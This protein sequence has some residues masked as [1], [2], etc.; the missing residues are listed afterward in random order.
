MNRVVVTGIGIVSPLGN[1]AEDFWKN[2]VSG[3]NGVSKINSFDTSEYDVHIAGQCKIDLQHYLDKK[4]LNKN[5]KFTAY[6]IIAADQAFKDSNLDLKKINQD[7]SGVIIGSGIG[8][9]NTFESQYKKLLKN[10]KRVSPFFIPGMIPDIASGQVAIKYGFTGVNYSILSACASSSHCIG[11]AYRNI[12][13]GYA[14]IIITGGSESTITPSAIAGFSNMKALTKN[15]D[16]KTASRPFDSDRD[17]FVMGEGS[18]ILILEQLEHALKRNA[19]IYA[20]I[21]GYGATADAFHL[22]SPHPEGNGACKAM[23]LAIRESG[24]DY[25]SFQ[26]INA[27]GTSTKQNDYI[28]TKAI[29]KVFKDHS[30]KISISSTKSMIGHL[31]GASGAVEMISTILSIKNSII[32]PT[33]NYSTKD[34]DC[35]LNYVPNKFISK[36]VDNALSNSFGFGGHNSVIAVGKYQNK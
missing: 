3:I 31:L 22:T 28:E 6:A 36:S 18:G 19:K 27:H 29:K 13:H 35:D 8:G 1:T 23:K 7:K 2:V 10:P 14:D 17:G 12:K 20:E 15:A 9:M 11:D 4:T 32:P 33:I 30:S 16:I 5:D 21:I 24:L 25:K 34:P 26:Y